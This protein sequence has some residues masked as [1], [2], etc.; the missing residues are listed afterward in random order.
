MMGSGKRSRALLVWLVA[1]FSTGATAC[2]G[3]NGQEDGADTSGDG[4]DALDRTDVDA[5]AMA[6]V[7]ED[8]AADAEADGMLP[9]VVDYLIVAADGLAET[10]AAFAAYREATGFATMVAPMSEVTAGLADRSDRE[11]AAA[12]RDRVRAAY[13][14]RDPERPFYLLILGDADAV[15]NDSPFLVPAAGCPYVDCYFSDNAYADVDGD[16]V[17][18]IAVGRIPVRSDADG[19]VVLDKV[20]VHESA[21]EAGPWNRLLSLYA[22]EGDFG[23]EVDPVI[24]WA[25]Q[26]VLQAVPYDFDVSFAYDNPAS[27]YD[28]APFG[29]KVLEFLNDGAIL[30][31]YMGHGGGEL[32]VGGIEGIRVEHRYPMLAF[33]ACGTGDYVGLGD[34]DPEWLLKRPGAPMAFLVSQNASH[35]Y[36]N[37]VL[38]RE[39]FAAVFEGRPAT[40][41]EAVRLMKWRTVHQD[42]EFRRTV[43]AAALALLSPEEMEEIRRSHLYIYN[44]LG[45]PALAMR[46]PPGTAAV[47]PGTGPYVAGGEVAFSGT[48]TAV[49]A[50]TAQV[51]LETERSVILATLTPVENP[52]LP[53]SWPVVQEN[54]AR[55]VDKVVAASE[56]PV[57]GGAFAGRITI[58]ADVPAGTYQLKVY[59]RDGGGD[60]IGHVEV[61]VR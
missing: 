52:E 24:E 17:P 61:V 12:V 44:L 42:D 13:A 46:F 15:G 4:D 3:G 48:V 10:A 41:G 51:T 49:A 47:D 58:P 19:M 59:A 56:V 1:A 27:P 5:D 2:A 37:I 38:S 22:G 45:D 39:L 9:S 43:D 60:A 50:G 8:A 20:R 14:G 34:S 26:M 35:P 11:L 53:E 7:G 28:Y 18:E 25:M 16:D 31:A 54:W 21:Y 55:A 33:F 32:D 40:F 23:P 29:S 6:D 57:V 30:T 36:G